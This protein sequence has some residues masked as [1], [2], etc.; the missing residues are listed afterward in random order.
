MTKPTFFSK[1]KP[2]YIGVADLSTLYG[3]SAQRIYQL[4]N[5]GIIKVE[6]VPGAKHEVF[7]LVETISGLFEYQ[8]KLADGG[9][10][11]GAA[12]KDELVRERISLTRAKRIETENKNA[13]AAG[14]LIDTEIVAHLYTSEANVL[15]TRI[16]SLPVEIT[17]K[18]RR[19]PDDVTAQGVLSDAID[20][21]LTV[22]ANRTPEET[23]AELIRSD[24]E[25]WSR[26]E[27]VEE[28]DDEIEIGDDE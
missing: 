28:T 19:S 11:A 21:I 27:A 20:E 24:P 13:R 23:K 5:E 16:R 10:A 25:F 9:N 14:E 18:L 6:T 1:T 17:A 26:I 12:G 3:V 7:P 15:K 4:R 22:F 8:R 2:E